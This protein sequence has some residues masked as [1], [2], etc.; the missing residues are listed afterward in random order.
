MGGDRHGVLE[1][2]RVTHREPPKS[3]CNRHTTG[4]SGPAAGNDSAE[5]RRIEILDR[6]KFKLVLP[7]YIP[8]KI[9]E[10]AYTSRIWYTQ[11]SCG[12]FEG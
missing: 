3:H 4:L 1:C 9:Q 12:R 8:L 7:P 6:V 10:R 2:L 5:K 11:N